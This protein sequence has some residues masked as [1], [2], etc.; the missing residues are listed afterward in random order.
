MSARLAERSTAIIV[1]G[2]HRS[3][4]SALTGVLSMVGANPGPSLMQGDKATNPKGFWE[5]KDV[6]AIHELLLSAL[7][8]SWYDAFPLPENWWLRPD[9]ARFRDELIIVLRR[10]FSAR[11]LWILKDPRLCRLLPMWLEILQELDAQPHFIICLRHPFEVAN[12][13]E[14]R[15]GIQAARA[16][17]LW[18]EHFIESE[19]WTRDHA[20]TLVDYAQLLVDWRK[21]VRQVTSDL[22]ISLPYD[23]TSEEYIDLFLEP[24]LRHHHA[25]TGF[26]GNH[27]VFQ[28]A[29]E[30]FQIAVSEP[31][32]QLANRLV[33]IAEEATQMT[34]YVEPWIA[35]IQAMQAKNMLLKLV[36]T[37]LVEANAEINRVKA[38]FSWWITKPIRLLANLPRF[39]SR[40]LLRIKDTSRNVH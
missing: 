33:A 1:L 40:L 24:S 10:D 32:S 27:R 39:M 25:Q 35:E 15:D 30:A 4:T 3:G 36:S 11:P 7:G 26:M 20:R 16:C 8:S 6:V 28:L 2:M 12:S 23:M 34:H 13:L 22:S 5:H 29:N 37:Q 18:L 31:P 17:L 21:T 9:V 38:T 14:Q 19:R